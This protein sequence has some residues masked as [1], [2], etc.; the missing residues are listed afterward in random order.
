[1]LNVD[2]ILAVVLFGKAS[3]THEKDERDNFAIL[4]SRAYAYLY[5]YVN[6]L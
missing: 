3:G 5:E 2:C 6:I 1:M 4:M